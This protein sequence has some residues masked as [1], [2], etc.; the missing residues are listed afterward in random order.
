MTGVAVR[1]SF[2]GA[3]AAELAAH[4]QRRRQEAATAVVPFVRPDAPQTSL[5]LSR[6]RRRLTFRGFDDF[7]PAFAAARAAAARAHGSFWWAK[8]DVSIMARVPP[9]WVAWKG[10]ARSGTSPRDLHFPLGVYWPGGELPIGPDY[11]APASVAQF[12]KPPPRRTLTIDAP[13][14]ELIAD[15]AD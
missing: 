6:P 1:A 15:A 9:Q 4:F 10:A 13:A 8:P 7:M 3:S 5:T 12:A 11:A 14:W 2:W